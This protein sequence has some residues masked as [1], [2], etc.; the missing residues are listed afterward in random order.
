MTVCMLG[1]VDPDRDE[2]IDVGPTRKLTIPLAVS[3]TP[4]TS[5]QVNDVVAIVVP[6]SAAN[7]S[8]FVPD[9]HVP[10]ET[11]EPSPPGQVFA[12]VCPS[13]VVPDDNVILSWTIS[14]Y[15]IP[16]I[17]PLSCLRY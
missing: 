5:I 7:C 3:E 6:A 17:L 4:G 13:A 8:L 14:L 10:H 9:P 2:R 11:K 1:E 12:V 15:S 16:I